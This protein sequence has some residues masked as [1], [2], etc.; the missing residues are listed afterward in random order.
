MPFNL[1]SFLSLFWISNFFFSS[2]RF[3][4][5]LKSSSSLSR[6]VIFSRRAL[7]LSSPMRS[8]SRPS[9][10]SSSRAESLL[11]ISPSSD[12]SFFFLPFLVATDPFLGLRLVSGSSSASESES[13]CFGLLFLVRTFR[14]CGLS[15]PEPDPDPDLDFFLSE[16]ES[17]AETNLGLDEL[18]ENERDLERLGLRDRELARELER[19][20]FEAGLA[21]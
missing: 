17:V 13:G 3:S 14:L 20:R 21:H 5:R 1:F 4:A 10:N 15:F 18:E 6:S 11:L 16:S 7:S 19:L 9:S 2:S 8:S 12:S